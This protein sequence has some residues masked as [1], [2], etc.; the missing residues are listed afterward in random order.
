MDN[1]LSS[2]ICLLIQD[3]QS[4]CL[5]RHKA[6]V[7]T[8]STARGPAAVFFAVSTDSGPAVFAPSTN[9]VRHKAVSTARGP[10]AGFCGFYCSLT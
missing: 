10:A 6:A 8:V 9:I 3:L 7:S 2:A 1:V 5:V 4:G